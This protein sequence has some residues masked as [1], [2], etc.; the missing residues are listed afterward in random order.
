MSDLA[1]WLQQGDP[2][3]PADLTPS[4]PV[5]SP[6]GQWLQ[7]SQSSDVERARWQALMNLQGQ[8]HRKP[9]DMAEASLL[10][11]A[12]GVPPKIIEKDLD[13][14]RA[15]AR[16][17]QIRKLVDEGLATP[18]FLADPDNAAAAQDEVEN[19]VFHERAWK[20]LRGAMAEL[21]EAFERGRKTT[22]MGVIGNRMATTGLSEAERQRLDQLR[23]SLAAVPEGEG[24]LTAAAELAGN[25]YDNLLSALQ[26]G[27]GAGTT[28]ATGA[29]IAGQAGPQ[30]ATPEEL[31][32]VPGA[33]VTG[34]T[35]GTA[36][37]LAR[38]SFIVEQ[39]H[40]Y[41]EMYYAAKEA[42]VEF[43]PQ[44]AAMLSAGVGLANAGL[45]MVGVATVA[46]PFKQALNR[47][48]SRD[49]LAQALKRQTRAGAAR[50]F[51][52]NYALGVGGETA[53]EMLQEIAPAVAQSLYDYYQS[54]DWQGLDTDQLAQNMAE[55]GLKTAQGMA[56]L[57]V[58]GPTTR[59]VGDLSRASQSRLQEEAMRQLQQG[60]VDSKLLQ[61]LPDRYRAF[62]KA[63]GEEGGIDAVSIEAE[64]F[65]SYWQSQV[66]NEAERLAIYDALGVRGQVE[67]A[68]QTGEDVQ[69]PIELW[70]SRIAPT[71]HFE[72]LLQDARLRPGAFTPREAREWVANGQDTALRT[73]IAQ[74][75]ADVDAGVTEIEAS[76]PGRVFAGVERSLTATGMDPEAA[77]KSATIH[78]G[79]ARVLEQEYGIDPEAFH[80]QEMG[81]RVV[82]GTPAAPTATRVAKPASQRGPLDAA[83]FLAGRGGIRDDQGHDLRR[84]RNLQ[85]L[86][87]EGPLIRQTGLSIDEAGEALWEAGFFGPLETTLRPDESQVLELLERTAEGR[88]FTPEE[89]DAAAADLAAASNA[90][91]EATLREGI[92]A[93]A[94]DMGFE[95]AEADVDAALRAM[96]EDGLEIDDAVDL[97][98][99][100]L[101]M[102]TLDDLESETGDNA[103][104]IPFDDPAE[105][106]EGDRAAGAR[107]DGR[108]GQPGDAGEGEAGGRPAEGLGG[109]EGPDGL[110]FEQAPARPRSHEARRQ[111]IP[112]A[113]D[114]PLQS[115]RNTT[116]LKAHPDYAAAKAGDRAAAV[117]L[118]TDL[119]PQKTLDEAAERFGPGA[120]F[121]AAHAEEASGRNAIPTTLADLLAAATDGRADDGIVQ[122]NRAF[123]TGAK[124]MERMMARPLFDGPVE[125]GGRYVLVDDVTTMGGTLAE[126]ANHIIDGGGQV[127]GVVTLANAS[128]TPTLGAS[129]QRVR[130]IE[131]RY[132]DAVREVFGT[133]PAALTAAEAQYVLGFRD[134]DSLRAR[135]AK[136]RQERDERLRA[137]GVLPSAPEE[138]QLGEGDPPTFFQPAWHGSPHIFDRFSL[139]AIGTGE[140]AQVYGWGLYF[141]GKRE[142]A[143]FY[144]DALARGPAWRTAA[145]EELDLYD[146]AREAEAGSPEALAASFLKQRTSVDNALW[147]AR[148]SHPDEFIGGEQEKQATIAG[149][150]EFKRRGLKKGRQSR[151]YKVEIPEDDTFLLWDRPFREQPEKVRAALERLDVDLFRRWQENGAWP[152]IAGRDLY[153]AAAGPRGMEM[154]NAEG[155]KAASLAL[156]DAGING[157]KYL[158]QGSRA[159]G[160]GT[161]NYVIFDDKL[162][163][164]VEF[165]QRRGAG[166]PRGSVSFGQDQTIIRLLPGADLSTFLHESGH[167]FLEAL[168]RVAERPTAS[169]RAV[170]DYRAIGAWYRDRAGA[171]ATEAARS[172]PYRVVPQAGGFE[173]RYGARVGGTYQKKAEADAAAKAANENV[174][175]RLDAMGEAG[176]IE[177]LDTGT[178]GQPDADMAISTALH[179][180]FARG[181]EAYLMEGRAPSPDMRSVFQAFRAWLVQIYRNL[182]GLDVEIDDRM[183]RV[184]DRLLA[185]D[186]QIALAEQQNIYAPLLDSAE[187][188]GLSREDFEQ[189]LRAAEAATRVAED[190]LLNDAMREV[191]RER[192]EEWRA[193]R[194]E[195]TEQVTE[196][197][198]RNPAYRAL[199][200]LTEGRLPDGRVEPE[201]R[202]LDK[203]QLV[204]EYGEEILQELGRGFG[205]AYQISG[206][207]RLEEGA[208][209]L[210]YRSGDALVEALRGLPPRRQAIAD[211]VRARLS[212]RFGDMMKDG[213]IVQAAQDAVH[214]DARGRFLEVE[215][216]AI[217]KRGAPD[218]ATPAEAARAFAARTIAEREVGKIQPDAILM[219]ERKA[220]MKAERALAAGMYEEAARQKRAQLINHYLY[221]EARDAAREVGQGRAYLRRVASRKGVRE[222]IAGEYLAQIDDLLARYDLAVSTTGKEIRARQDLRAFIAEKEAAGEAIVVDPKLVEDARR[223]S[224]KELSLEE[225][226]GLRDAVRNLQH[227]GRK[228]QEL[229]LEEERRQLQEIADD[230]VMQIG[231]THREVPTGRVSRASDLARRTRGQVAGALLNA[232]TILRE[233]DGWEDQGPVYRNIKGVIDKAYSE[234]LVPLQERMADQLTALFGRFSRA[235]AKKMAKARAR[236]WLDGE[237]LSRWELIAIALNAGNDGNREALVESG[238][239]TA[240]QVDQTLAELTARELEF[241]QATWDLVEGY[242]P[243][244]AALEERR[245]GVAPP[246]VEAT[247]I[248]VTSSDGQV[249][250]MRGGYYPLKYDAQLSAK[251]DEETVDEFMQGIRAGRFARA[252]TRHGHTIERVGSGGRPVRLNMSVL[253]QHL[254]QVAYDLALGE[255]VTWADKVLKHKDV[256]EAF[257]TVGKREAW[258]M[259][260]IWLKDVATGEVIAGDVVSRSLR[261]VRVGFTISRIGWNLGT[262]VIQPTGFL[263][264][265]VQIGKRNALYGLMQLANVSRWSGPNSIFRQVYDQ[266]AFMRERGTTF[267]KDIYDTIRQIDRVALGGRNIVERLAAPAWAVKGGFF[268]MA[269]TQQIVDVA[270]WL[271]AYRQ[272]K[273]K[274]GADDRK[275]LDHADR[276]VARSQASGLFSDRTAIERGTLS[277]NH[278]QVEVVRMFTALASYMIAK[279]NVAYERIKRTNPRSPAQVA[280][281]T[282]DLMLL[283]TVE[284][285]II[286]LIR[287][288]FPDEDDDEGAA[289]WLARESLFA[290][291]GGIPLV[292]EFA[293]ESQGFRGGGAFASALDLYGRA[294]AQVDQG[295]FDKAFFKANIDFAGVLLHYPSSQI[296]RTFDAFWRDVVEKDDVA[297]IEYLMKVDTEDD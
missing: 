15:K 286:G 227:I 203:A 18:R 112:P 277:T 268:L 275:A 127:V 267:N 66:P 270:T 213:S 259:L 173:V 87:P 256:K 208:E 223:R 281:L 1:N 201:H 85:K 254:H 237:E 106:A 60:A 36:A 295:E 124:A 81:L 20:S 90:D 135:A 58:P 4:E 122:A 290:M 34:L 39:G 291:M 68:R 115:F 199:R 285:L 113:A 284:A 162:V 146:L 23:E 219:A 177:F 126:M 73:A 225:F 264:T 108:E 142:V 118:V 55:I 50:A 3:A 47:A 178:T 228:E 41:V 69:I 276:M 12:I 27:V 156:R 44:T 246:K 145:G 274:F 33:F 176:V 131:R 189:Y 181:F 79:F 9:D 107:R 197:I 220:G 170:D 45:E 231:Q 224:Y 211:K 42:G 186:E 238:K 187:A 190:E 185:T 217:S 128:R 25:M 136:A 29:A 129:A 292:R 183:R 239:F 169:Q 140:G 205:R 253:T 198:D 202:R 212:E 244:I 272:G 222:A 266:S 114:P 86:T 143:E 132:G 35:A 130:E 40:S 104:D 154:R 179:E 134:A 196:E 75:Q 110:T 165:E 287:G 7:R 261:W 184:F 278:R 63:M 194:D 207:M 52:G 273:A 83:R 111:G 26:V 74:A 76:A 94:R 236:D 174:A 289:E 8:A 157:I 141:A 168:K 109:A 80:A 92:A 258:N 279:N 175:G 22:E 182:R 144:R 48:F 265:S 14:A 226:R 99:E 64:A 139:D 155:Q 209:L 263:Q 167:F 248:E 84:G 138:G 51:A 21:P 70:Q 56:V 96:A 166:G 13:A 59:L 43:D 252:Q 10:S 103:Y 235:E 54:G 82:S 216:R 61:R 151:L 171:V 192:T 262:A 116:P 247:P 95:F 123:H 152:H 159:T 78:L 297:L 160:D 147:T 30:I 260:D 150:E 97:Q 120:I 251:V 206:G 210:G 283:Y 133:E 67:A 245:T 271:G 172:G 5:D 282:I 243:E 17:D 188:A 296:N 214:S 28:A 72:A 288:Y 137:R 32:T 164:I 204:A 193:A 93:T 88:V 234:R 149:L 100:R 101:A 163:E 232:D 2:G 218:M 229:R 230:L 105:S 153:S 62:V 242:W 6:L 215:L 16:N 221:M 117:R 49:V 71:D 240:E 191:A 233:M 148:H 241:V 24:F 280:G 121:A 91:Q 98:I 250:Q 57:A 38:R 65:E 11:G 19:L 31:I 89:A 195:I 293:A 77:R 200:Y 257:Q 125:P 102:Q 269:K 46:R 161:Y 119:V 53:T 37:E 180:Q 158:D 294:A 249:V 255:A